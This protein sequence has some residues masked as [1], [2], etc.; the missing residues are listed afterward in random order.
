L[1]ISRHFNEEPVLVAG[2]VPAT[3]LW[4]IVIPLLSLIPVLRAPVVWLSAAIFLA[5][6]G[7][8]SK[9]LILT[10]WGIVVIGSVEN[11]LYLLLVGDSHVHMNPTLL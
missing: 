11:L 3:L 4:G 8:W 5:L 7:S 9:A 6:M 2:A 1:S 10:T